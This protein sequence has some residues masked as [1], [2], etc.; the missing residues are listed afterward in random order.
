MDLHWKTARMRQWIELGERE[1]LSFR[2][3][4]ERAGV[5]PRTLSR[6]SRMLRERRAEEL[7][8]PHTAAA[9]RATLPDEAFVKLEESEPA[10]AGRIEI[11]LTGDRRII[12]EGAI[13]VEALV[14]VIKAVEQC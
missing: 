9:A 11:V 3:L 14:R 12:V 2:E 1:D 13:D 8:N 10:P 6:W 4:A 7:H 5:H